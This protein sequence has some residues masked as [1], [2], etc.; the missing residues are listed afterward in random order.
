MEN[1]VAVNQEYREWL[2]DIK[3]YIRNQQVKAA[4]RVNEE[5]LK[6]Y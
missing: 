4:V 2:K 1:N 6:V 3:G 5:L